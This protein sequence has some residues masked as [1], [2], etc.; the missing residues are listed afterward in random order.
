MIK[1]IWGLYAGKQA[2]THGG[3]AIC[4]MSASHEQRQ[5]AGYWLT[6]C[7]G[8]HRFG[9]SFPA[10]LRALEEAQQTHAR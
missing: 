3:S 4:I 2:S 8:A 9:W 6:A 10:G 1:P 7:S 5:R